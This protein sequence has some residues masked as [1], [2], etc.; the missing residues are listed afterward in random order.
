[1][2]CFLLG[3]ITGSTDLKI[4]YNRKCKISETLAKRL[5]QYHIV[6]FVKNKHN[7]KQI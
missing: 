1:M 7:Y 4:L 2:I 6:P 3:M 5:K